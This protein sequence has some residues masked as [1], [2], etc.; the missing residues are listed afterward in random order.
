[1]LKGGAD[2]VQGR[3]KHFVLGL[4]LRKAVRRGA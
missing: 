1:M 3:R 4:A 2:T